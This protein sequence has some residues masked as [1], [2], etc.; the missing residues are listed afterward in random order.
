[1]ILHLADPAP[2]PGVTDLNSMASGYNPRLQ[3][4]ILKGLVKVE[5]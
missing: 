3:R 1:M 2:L 5:V 4:F